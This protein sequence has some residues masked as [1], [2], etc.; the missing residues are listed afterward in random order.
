[1]EQKKGRLFLCPTPIGNLEDITLRVLKILKDVEVIAAED[2][3]VTRKLMNHY[4]IKKPLIS[5]HEHNKTKK[6]E[7]IIKLLLE[8]RDVALVSDAGTPGISD[9]GE[10]LVKAAIGENI[11]VVPLPGP[12]AFVTA[13]IASGL[14]TSRF[15]FEGFL[16][17]KDKEREKILNDLINEKRTII[18]YE[19]PHRIVKFL[20][21]L[22]EKMGNRRVVIARE[23]TK[24][25][26]EFFRGTVEEA[27]LKFNA[28]EP[29]GEFVILIEGVSKE[30]TDDISVENLK[31]KALE[32]VGEYL[33]G[34]MTKSQAVKKVSKELNISKNELYSVIHKEIT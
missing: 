12:S 22:K 21:E 16:P 24:I 34:G 20:K 33:K 30:E 9:P 2:T 26:E 29:R 25:H 7:V 23:L 15:A 18:F 10:E 27:L 4:G 1:M 6:G 19:S 32:K 8:G 31:E 5:Y 28:E 3:R 17:K 14:S 11:E 13:L